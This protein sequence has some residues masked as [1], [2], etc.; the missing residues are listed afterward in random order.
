MRKVSFLV[1]G[2]LAFASCKKKGCTDKTAVNY[3]ESAKKDDG[4]C[5]YKPVIIDTG[6]IE[7]EVPT[8]YVF[9]RNGESTVSFNGQKER[10]DMLSELVTYMKTANTPGTALE[11]SKL[12]DMYANENSPFN[13]T[14]L[15]NST[16]KL[17][18]KTAGDDPT[19]IDY[20]EKLMKEMVA[21]SDSTETGKYEGKSGMPG[22]VQS[23]TKTYLQSA[24][25]HEYTQLIEKGLMGAVMM[26][27]IS[28]VYLGDS[29]MNVENEIVEEGMS[30]TKMEHHWDEAFGYLLGT[31]NFPTEGTDRFWGKYTNGRNDLLKSNEKLMN[32]FIRGRFAI[33]QNDETVRNAQIEIIREELEKVCAA[34]VIHYLKSAKSDIADDALRNHA[35][36]EAWAFIDNLKYAFSGKL[37]VTQIEA[38]KS[39]IGDDFYAVSAGN[40]TSVI[41]DLSI[42]YGFESIKDQL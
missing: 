23:G 38:H 30:Y 36:S 11:E 3:V 16:K 15:N 6:G 27:Q 12:L 28:H 10:L 33:T 42:T 25:G 32:A 24:K 34:T 19:I 8:S 31:V 13:N 5:E 1:V 21:D 26:H 14:D 4:S 20:F 9:E 17:Q 35:L 39:K 22:V 40:L 29:K 2:L 41:D 37:T 7:V 18:N